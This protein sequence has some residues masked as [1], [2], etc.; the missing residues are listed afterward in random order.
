[1]TDA[2]EI[3]L[4]I[5]GVD[6][7]FNVTEKLA[8]QYPLKGLQSHENVRSSSILVIVISFKN[9]LNPQIQST[10]KLDIIQK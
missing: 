6:K 4:F 3:A 9:F 10:L 2:V 1:M 8:S 5:C 7:A